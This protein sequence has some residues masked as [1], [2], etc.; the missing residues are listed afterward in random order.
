MFLH[1]G[2]VHIIPPDVLEHCIGYDSSEGHQPVMLDK[3]TALTEVSIAVIVAWWAI[4]A[5]LCS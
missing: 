3:V 4:C 2:S 1:D 5:P